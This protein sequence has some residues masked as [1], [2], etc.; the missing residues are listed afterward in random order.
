MEHG[1]DARDDGY[2]FRQDQETEWLG[3]IWDDFPG[4]WG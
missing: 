2:G 1:M 3:W 4:S